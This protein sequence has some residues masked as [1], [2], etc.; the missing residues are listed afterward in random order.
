MTRVVIIIL[1]WLILTPANAFELN[2]GV[3]KM[4]IYK[5]NQVTDTK[6]GRGVD[7]AKIA[8]PSK[9]YVTYSNPLGKFEMPKNLTPPYVLSVKKQG[10]EPFSLTV[11]SYGKAPLK[12]TISKENTNKIAID[13]DTFHLGDNSFSMNSANAEDFK[14]RSA[15][16]IYQK[17]FF[18]KNLTPNENVNLIIGSLIGVDTKEARRLGQ[19]NV[20]DAYSSPVKIFFNSNEVANL[21]IN[22]DNQKIFIPKTFIRQ[23]AKNSIKILTGVNLTQDLYT[24]YDDFEF[25][26]LFI[27]YK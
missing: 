20:T 5:M 2:G 24:D 3:E 15:G 4:E 1:L 14:S 8:I 26:N 17:S 16:V 6:S 23:N 12:I 21:K 19:T 18:V 11:K 9:N 25:T 7:N 13:A 10:Y 22:G 27:E